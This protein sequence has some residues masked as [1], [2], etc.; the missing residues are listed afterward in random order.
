MWNDLKGYVQRC[1]AQMLTFDLRSEEGQAMIEYSLIV[2][3]IS[4]AAVATFTPIGT[5]ILNA[6]TTVQNAF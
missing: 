3:L 5:A 4:I 6:F 2:A 1:H